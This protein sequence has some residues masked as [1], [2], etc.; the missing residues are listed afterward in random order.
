MALQT[1]SKNNV[2]HLSLLS[3]NFTF[4]AEE[5]IGLFLVSL[6]ANYGASIRKTG[7]LLHLIIVGTITKKAIDVMFPRCY[8]NHNIF[9]SQS[10]R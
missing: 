7:K 5:G 3:E 9:A 10:Q 2:T 8:E 1:A 4:L 6:S